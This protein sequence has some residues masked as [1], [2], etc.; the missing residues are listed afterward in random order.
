M[1]NPALGQI[2]WHATVF[3]TISVT[4]T[5]SGRTVS[6]PSSTARCSSTSFRM[7]VS[8]ATAPSTSEAVKAP[9]M[10]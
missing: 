10:L 1:C 3:S 5:A 7:I 9:T 2:S 4:I 6:H 8:N